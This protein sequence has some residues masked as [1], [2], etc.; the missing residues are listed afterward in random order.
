MRL[1]VCFVMVDVGS[2]VFLSL[3]L[4]VVICFS[5]LVRAAMS[6]VTVMK[7]FICFVT[8]VRDSHMFCHC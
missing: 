2:D 1:V 4:R 8:V 3:I 7:V 5:L 6:V